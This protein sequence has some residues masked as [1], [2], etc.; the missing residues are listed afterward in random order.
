MHGRS[1]AHVA[2]CRQR[3]G[4]AG[5][6]GEHQTQAIAR[7]PSRQP[8]C[9]RA[10]SLGRH[11][12]AVCVLR[13]ATACG[14]RRC[15]LG[16]ASGRLREAVR[17]RPRIAAFA[18]ADTDSE[19]QRIRPDS[20]RGGSCVVP[21]QHR[22]LAHPGHCDHRTQEHIRADVALASLDHCG[23]DGLQRRSDG[24]LLDLPRF[25]G[26]F[27]ACVFVD[28]PVLRSILDR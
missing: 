10:A 1:G 17:P 9:A 20:H 14:R 3:K 25:G 19:R 6:G 13:L 4:W 7:P 16:V 8:W 2:A 24:I 26:Q 28:T 11:R 5:G 23:T 21:Q 12:R 15:S 22:D 18:C 27:W